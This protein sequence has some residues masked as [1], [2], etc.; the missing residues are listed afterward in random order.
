[1]VPF[2]M[3]LPPIRWMHSSSPPFMLNSLSISYCL[4]RP[5]QLH[6]TKSTII[7]L[8]IMQFSPTSCHLISLRSKCSP[9]HPVP[10]HPPPNCRNSG[11]CPSSCL[12]FKTQL[13]STQLYRFVRTSQETHYVS[14]KSPTG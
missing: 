13:N 4:S 5:F 6:Q 7:K 8:L 2:R 11:H 3:V 9:Q 14:A 12:L 10:K 1:L